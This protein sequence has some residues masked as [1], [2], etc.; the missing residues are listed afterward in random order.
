MPTISQNDI[1]SV[2]NLFSLITPITE[3]DIIEVCRFLKKVKYSKDYKILNIGQTETCINFLIKGIVHMYTF[4]D[5]EKFTIN[6]S[7][8]GML[9]NSLDSYINNRPTSEIQEVIADVEI[10]CLEKKD[11]ETLMQQNKTFCYIYAKLFENVLNMREQRTL[12]LQYKSALKRFEH[13]I[14]NIANAERYMQE[15]PQK[16]VAQYLGLAPETYCRVKKQ[17]LKKKVNI[18]Y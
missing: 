16:L 14:H 2:S 3:T 18:I 6:I 8:P 11:V 4:V 5:G 1:D 15:V 10:L 9:F 12:L 17:Y 13:F 7:L